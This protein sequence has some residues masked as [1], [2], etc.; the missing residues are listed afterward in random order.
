MLVVNSL[1]DL[2]EMKVG[3]TLYHKDKLVRTSDPLIS[4]IQQLASS[5]KVKVSTSY[6]KDPVTLIIKIRVLENS[7]TFDKVELVLL[8]GRKK[9][10]SKTYD[11]EE[12][13][14][15]EG[16]SLSLEWRFEVR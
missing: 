11:T 1:K 15:R 16:D 14:L 9:V 6:K 8:K 12:I 3:Y 5:T 7:L 13:T 4:M 10:Y 2:E